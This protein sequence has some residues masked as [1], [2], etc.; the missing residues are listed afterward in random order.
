MLG[1]PTHLGTRVH[2]HPAT[3]IEQTPSR[4]TSTPDELLDLIGGILEGEEDRPKF[5]QQV[6][7][8]RKFNGQA[9]GFELDSWGQVFKPC[10]GVAA[11]LGG[12]FDDLAIGLEF[13][14]ELLDGLL[15]RVL[16]NLAVDGHRT[17][18]PLVAFA[19]PGDFGIA[20]HGRQAIEEIL[21]AK[22]EG[23][24][25][26]AGSEAIQ[27]P[28]RRHAAHLKY[29]LDIRPAD[30][31]P[32]GGVERF[33]EGGNA[34]LPT[35]ADPERGQGRPPLPG[36]AAGE[37][38]GFRSERGQLLSLNAPQDLGC[39]EGRFLRK[40]L[41]QCF[42]ILEP[43]GFG[44]APLD[45][46]GPGA[47]LSGNDQAGAAVVERI[48][49]VA[50]EGVVIGLDNPA[51]QGNRPAGPGSGIKLFPLYVKEIGR[52]ARGSPGAGELPDSR[53]IG[54]IDGG[55]RG[56]VLILKQNHSFEAANL[57]AVFHILSIR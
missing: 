7:K 28:N 20:L 23:V 55:E 40:A 11:R 49:G 21:A 2:G 33:E 50:D 39:R 8:P 53:K 6:L 31:L 24:A 56:G 48:A 44:P 38:F 18:N 54:G 10:G 32:V 5:H 36:Q 37:V 42:G 27:N 52:E 51:G 4:P 35:T 17:Y 12:T 41:G 1:I 34:V 3:R 15:D 45:L 22:H 57:K 25:G 47:A 30:K 16:W 14:G 29:P 19:L 43:F 46:P 9:A 26:A 13:A